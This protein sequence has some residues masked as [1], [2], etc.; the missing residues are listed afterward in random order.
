MDEERPPT[1]NPTAASLLG[2]LHE[3]PMTGWSLEQAV[4][5]SLGGFWNVTRSQIYR[6][7][8]SLDAA[9]LVE[10]E[11]VGPR[12]RRPYR[13]TEAGRRAFAEWIAH[14][15]GEE[16]I[17]FP[18][19]L[20]VYFRAH[21]EPGRMRRFLREHELLHLRRLERYERDVRRVPEDMTGPL[22]TLRFGIEYERAVLRWFAS[23]PD[24]D[25]LRQDAPAT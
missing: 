10:P 14:P 18:L 11:E 23:I 4:D 15:P 5:R 24:Y 1:P 25:P 13:I 8:R 7:L 12:E 21:V 22:L 3:S 6:E 2:F 19:L 9:G 17:R 20:T 16:V